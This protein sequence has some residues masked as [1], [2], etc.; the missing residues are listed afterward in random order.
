MIAILEVRC[1]RRIRVKVLSFCISFQHQSVLLHLSLSSDSC[2]GRLA[3]SMLCIAILNVWHL[4]TVLLFLEQIFGRILSN[5]HIFL[6]S[7]HVV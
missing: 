5:D 6:C 1:A 7:F 2:R 3:T 4:L